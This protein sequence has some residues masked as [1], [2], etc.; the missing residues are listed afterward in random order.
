[1]DPNNKLMKN[2]IRLHTT[3]LGKERIRRNLKLGDSID[4]VEWCKKQIE[5]KKSSIQQNGKNWYV[6]IDDNILVINRTS[7]T[8]ITAYKERK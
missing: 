7:Y 5:S 1:M 2:I 4:I 3:E 8:I 6:K